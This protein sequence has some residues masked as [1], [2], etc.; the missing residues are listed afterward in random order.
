[1]SS[2]PEQIKA[3]LATLTVNQYNIYY[4]D[5]YK[6]KPITNNPQ[7]KSWGIDN[8]LFHDKNGAIILNKKNLD[9]LQKQKNIQINIYKTDN[10]SYVSPIDVIIDNNFT[11]EYNMDI[12]V[13]NKVVYSMSIDSSDFD[14]TDVDQIES[15]MIEIFNSNSEKYIF[16]ILYLIH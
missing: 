12:L 11:F 7:I 10:A 16:V 9:I 5:N 3:Y 1:M 13:N 2:S 15:D 4:T 8:N 14:I 6:L